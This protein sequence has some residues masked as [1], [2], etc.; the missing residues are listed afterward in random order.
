MYIDIT[1]SEFKKTFDEKRKE[2][3]MR[4]KVGQDDGDGNDR[5][6]MVMVMVMV[7][8]VVVKMYNLYVLCSVKI[9]P[10]AL[11]HHSPLVK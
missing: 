9:I 5:I 2:R 7:M 1:L 4:D 6:V 3:D 11:P 8:I 10:S